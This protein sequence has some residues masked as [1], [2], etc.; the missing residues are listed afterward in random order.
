M[1]LY[2][3]EEL[4]SWQAL[5]THEKLAACASIGRL[6]E[7]TG[8]LNLHMTV[9]CQ[10]CHVAVPPRGKAVFKHGQYFCLSCGVSE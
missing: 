5:T 6:M 3:R 10:K 9:V 1:N 8:K 4:A 2:N 7:K